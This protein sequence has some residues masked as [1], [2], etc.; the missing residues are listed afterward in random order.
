MAFDEAASIAG[1]F[2]SLFRSSSSSSS[3]SDWVLDGRLVGFSELLYV[4]I[5]MSI[6]DAPACATR[7]PSRQRLGACSMSTLILPT[8]KR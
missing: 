5:Y 1:A 8:S 4:C 6:P 3:S 7:V 2:I